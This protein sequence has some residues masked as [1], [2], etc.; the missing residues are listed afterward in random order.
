MKIF[1][2][3]LLILIC[4][5]ALF[6]MIHSLKNLISS[7]KGGKKNKNVID[8]SKKKKKKEDDKN[9]LGNYDN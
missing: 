3:I 5:G 6:L 7:I 8:A 1:S 9:D 2:T 4:V